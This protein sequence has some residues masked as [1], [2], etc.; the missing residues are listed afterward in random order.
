MSKKKIGLSSLIFMNVSALYGIRWIAKSTS[1]SFGL[2]LGAIPMWFIFAILYFIPGA[3]I[4]AELASTYKSK[5]GGLHDWVV[6]AYGEKYGFMVSWLN[7]TA[8]LFWYSSF[9]TFLAINVSYAIGN[10]GL[11]DNKIFVLVLSLIVFWG[12]SFISTKDIKFA[13]LF[14]NTGALG[15]TI[16]SILIIV[17]AFLAVVV[18]KKIPSASTYTVQTITP[19]FNP[20]SLVAISAI[21]FGFTGAETLANFIT[22]I[23]KPEKNFPKA[24]IVSALI[25][26]T[27]YVLGSIA[28]TSLMSPNEITASKGILDSLAVAC[29]A[30]GIPAVFIQVIAAGIAISVLG[31][32][33]LYIASPI[34]MLFGSVNEGIFP[35]KL[36][37]INEHNVP[38]NAVMFQAVLVSS[39]LTLTALLPNVDTI[40]NILVTMT[41]L[42]SLFP[43]VLL[44]LSYIKLRKDNKNIER[45]YTMTKNDFVAINI[46]RFLL[47]VTLLGVIL[48]A[49]PVMSTLKD[50][51]IYEIEMIGGGA[52]VIISGLMMWRRYEKSLKS[53]S[54]GSLKSAK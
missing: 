44:F 49:T 47:V 22:Q 32:I 13:K 16:P 24:V 33:V 51:I 4:C 14:T 37:K 41:A 45:D 39:I 27:L 11:A 43:Y 38:A 19:D 26:A 15:S 18:L 30:L 6:E 8:K 5:D 53:N 12:L 2:G 23:D 3:L 54:S 9:L 34:K 52:L 48:T 35:K 10:Q 40:Y 31:A 1:S 28:I 25:V 17:F 20:N 36:T 46:G 50:N 42:T 7:W 21:I 29:E